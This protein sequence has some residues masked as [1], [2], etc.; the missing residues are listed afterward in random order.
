M[1]RAAGGGHGR[2]RRGHTKFSTLGKMANFNF[3]EESIGH[4]DEVAK[5]AFQESFIEQIDDAASEN[6]EVNQESGH[7]EK[8]PEVLKTCESFLL[9][10]KDHPCK[11]NSR[12][13]N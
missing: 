9:L 5:K 2:G 10:L 6:V 7:L 13:L 1:R 11:K 12:I 3:E 8:L 4:E